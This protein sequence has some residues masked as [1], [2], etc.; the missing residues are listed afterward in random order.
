MV[1]NFQILIS[2]RKQDEHDLKYKTFLKINNVTMDYCNYAK[3]GGGFGSYLIDFA[4]K[5]V[6]E[7]GNLFKRCPI[8]GHFYLRNYI[9]DISGLPFTIPIGHYSAS[10][11]IYMKNKTMENQVVDCL[12]YGELIN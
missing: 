3:K 7:H 6:A 9:P 4:A 8:R 11:F 12:G 1:V 2:V 10:V 5:N